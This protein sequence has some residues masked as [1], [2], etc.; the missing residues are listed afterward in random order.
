LSTLTSGK[1]FT[2]AQLSAAAAKMAAR[3]TKS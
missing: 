3:M 1:G 2:P